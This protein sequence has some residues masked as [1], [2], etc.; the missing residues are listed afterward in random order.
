[1]SDHDPRGAPVQAGLPP[2]VIEKHRIALDGTERVSYYACGVTR[3]SVREA[4]ADAEQ[5]A[6]NAALRAFVRELMTPK[7]WSASTRG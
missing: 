2:I 5:M 3:S 6:S 4:V 1:M 7:R